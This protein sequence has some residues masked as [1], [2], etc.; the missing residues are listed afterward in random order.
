MKNTMSIKDVEAA[1][2]RAKALGFEIETTE[3]TDKFFPTTVHH[4]IKNHKFGWYQIILTI[5]HKSELHQR[6]SVSAFTHSEYNTTGGTGACAVFHAL[7]DL[8]ERKE[9]G[10]L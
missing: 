2:G 4:M 5:R 7:N 8:A 3:S 10:R 6:M 9:K 1:L